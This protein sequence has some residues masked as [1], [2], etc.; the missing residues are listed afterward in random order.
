MASSRGMGL[1]LNR[2]LVDHSLKFSA[3]IFPAHLAG[4]TDSGG[5]HGWVDVQVSLSVSSRVPYYTKERLTLGQTPASGD[6]Y[7][8]WLHSYVEY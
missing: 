6:F 4:R 5:Y 3:T 8:V 7:L 2:T 1:K